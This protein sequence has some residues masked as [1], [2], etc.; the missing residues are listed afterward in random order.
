MAGKII[1]GL[2]IVYFTMIAIHTGS[3]AGIAGL[4]FLTSPIFIMMLLNDKK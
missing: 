3:Y 1:S 4:I 2:L